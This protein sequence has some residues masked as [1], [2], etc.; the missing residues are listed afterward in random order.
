MRTR[1][2]F[3]LFVIYINITAFS[4]NFYAVTGPGTDGD[5][6][7]GIFATSG[8]PATPPPTS[9]LLTMLLL[10]VTTSPVTAGALPDSPPI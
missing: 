3:L 8:P 6:P 10:A 7:G 5:V 2:R 9:A 4:Y 1:V